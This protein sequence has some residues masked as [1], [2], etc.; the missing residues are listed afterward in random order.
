MEKKETIIFS[1]FSEDYSEKSYKL[2]F[3]KNQFEFV[4]KSQ[5]RFIESQKKG[6]E[7]DNGGSNYF[8]ISKWLLKKLKGFQYYGI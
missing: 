3:G 1:A 8:E 4:P 6:N 5:V 2:L 7:F